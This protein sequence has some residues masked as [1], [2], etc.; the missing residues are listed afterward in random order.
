MDTLQTKDTAME[1]A[2]GHATERIIKADRAVEVLREELRTKDASLT[3]DHEKLK[4]DYEKLQQDHKKAKSDLQAKVKAAPTA[5]GTR[6]ADMV[7]STVHTKMKKKLETTINELRTEVTELNDT[8]AE[9]QATIDNLT[10]EVERCKDES[11]KVKG[12]SAVAGYEL[13]AWRDRA[14]RFN[15]VVQDGTS[16]Q[17]P[18]RTRVESPGTVSSEFASLVVTEMSGICKQAM[19]QKEVT[20]FPSNGVLAIA[21]SSKE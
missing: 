7:S 11:A 17:L 15:E 21:P 18:K 20:I 4:Q 3:H 16:P 19:A 6:S 14:K 1:I 10:A 5:R 2:L 13:E 12:E 9:L 8:V